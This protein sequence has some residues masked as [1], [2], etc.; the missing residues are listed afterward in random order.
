MR[1]R[2]L[3]K[4]MLKFATDTLD[5]TGWKWWHV[6]APMVA[7]KGEWRPYRKAAGLPDIFAFH[8]D[9]PRMMIVELKGTGGK[10]SEAQREFLEMAR[11]VADSIEEH[12]SYG[13]ERKIGVVVLLPGMEDWFAA[14]CKSKVLA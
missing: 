8:A 10:L 13:R 12:D 9:P 11:D 1:E 6:P 4:D 3:E 14:M 2:V 5:A 7:G